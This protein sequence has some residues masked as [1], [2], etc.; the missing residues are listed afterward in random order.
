MK[1][2]YTIQQQNILEAVLPTYLKQDILAL[3][4]GCKNN[5]SLLDCLVC[6]VQG[7]I[8]SA[9]YNREITKTEAAFLRK[10]YLGLDEE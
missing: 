2:D 4:E 5:S 7:Y 9:F 6:E 3:A 10:K 1:K 8:N